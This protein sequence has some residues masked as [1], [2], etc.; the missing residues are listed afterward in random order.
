M[1]EMI[2][3]KKYFKGK[4]VLD[5]ISLQVTDGEIVGLLG[6]NGSG[7]TTIFRI[8]CGV[9]QAD[10]G[11]I[12]IDGIPLELY[13]GKIGY[14]IEE[15]NLYPGITVWEQLLL[16]G[17]LKG[18]KKG[19]PEEEISQWLEVFEIDR[20]KYW[21]ICGLSKGNQQL[22]QI[23]GGLLGNAKVVVLDE[24]F[25]GLDTE[26]SKKLI[27]VLREYAKGRNILVSMHQYEYVPYLLDRYYVMEEGKMTEEVVQTVT[28]CSL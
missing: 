22:V 21:K 6:S 27:R 28:E 1:L 2:Q 8:L 23:I 15:R 7:K 26:N 17:K 18:M 25:N 20:Y 5:G 4:T 24:P 9:Y 11:S 16:T 19:K 14:V 10:E 3:I 12:R 13:K